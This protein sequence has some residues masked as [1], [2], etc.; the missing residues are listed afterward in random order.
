MEPSTPTPPAPLRWRDALRRILVLLHGSPCDDAWEPGEQE[1]EMLQMAGF[2]PLLSE[3][4]AGHPAFPALFAEEVL[5]GRRIEAHRRIL[6]E[7]ARRLEGKASPPILFKGM[8]ACDELYD[9]PSLRVFTDVDLL[10]PSA[11]L[12]A[13]DEAIRSLGGHCADAQIA[14]HLLTP[15]LLQQRSALFQRIDGTEILA[16]Q[17]RHHEEGG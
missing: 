9:K 7:L 17:N 6:A 16:H 3:V 5:N 15:C 10:I 13:W 4:M 1:L 8:A 14:R 11:D 12:P 2:G